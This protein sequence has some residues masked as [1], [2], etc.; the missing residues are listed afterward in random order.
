MK[1]E[2]IA[3]YVNNLEKQKNSTL[4]IH[5]ENQITFI[6]AKKTLSLTL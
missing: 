6:T 2:H 5:K 4:N 3:M 1:I